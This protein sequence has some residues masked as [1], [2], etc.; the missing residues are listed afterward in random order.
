V[1][2]G[3]K[4]LK[5]TYN[6]AWGGLYLQSA[7]IVGTGHRD[8]NNPANTWLGRGRMAPWML[9]AMKGSRVKKEDFL[10]GRDGFGRLLSSD[11]GGSSCA[12]AAMAALLDCVEMHRILRGD[13]IVSRL[14]QQVPVSSARR[15]V[16]RPWLCHPVAG[17]LD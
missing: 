8:P 5:A 6:Q 7:G 14:Q 2:A 4:S 16:A 12:R 10:V 15:T 11:E 1:Y 17:F 9:A 13:G 3:S